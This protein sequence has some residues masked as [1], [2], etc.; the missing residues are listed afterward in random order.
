M[1][2]AVE[3]VGE[4]S[5]R[6]P[7][8]CAPPLRHRDREAGAA[9]GVNGTNTWLSGM[10]P[11][12]VDLGRVRDRG[13]GAARG[14]R[15]AAG[16]A[17]RHERRQHNQ[18]FVAY[19]PPGGGFT[20]KVPEGWARH[21]AG[22]AIA[23]TDKLNAIRMES[24]PAGAA[25][26]RRVGAQRTSCPARARRS[27][28]SSRARS[29]RSAGRPAPPSSSPT[30][31]TRRPNPVTGKAGTDAVE[32]YVFL[33]GGRSVVLTLAGPKGAD[34]VDPWRIVTDSLRWTR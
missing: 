15:A 13:L 25:L 32:R 7:R 28:A 6:R 20:V 5:R 18:A 30:S 27:R 11:G 10:S 4:R 26:D 22:G 24:R 17:G 1:P 33:H 3:L 8:R 31:P 2:H 9:A 14:R 23:F 29:A 12:R 34:N 21:R 16:G 19:A